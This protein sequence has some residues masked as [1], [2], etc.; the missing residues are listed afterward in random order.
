MPKDGF[1]GSWVHSLYRIVWTF[2]FSSDQP[3]LVITMPMRC[4]LLLS[5]TMLPFQVSPACRVEIN[6]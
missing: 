2:F 6:V 4:E 3:L 1:E 5:I